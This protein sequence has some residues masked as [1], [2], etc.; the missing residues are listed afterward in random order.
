MSFSPITKRASQLF[1]SDKNIWIA[2]RKHCKRVMAAKSNWAGG[3]ARLYCSQL[4]QRMVCI[5]QHR[6][7]PVFWRLNEKRPDGY[8]IAAAVRLRRMSVESHQ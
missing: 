1:D 5:Y 6:H 3:G 4:D 7:V 2:A 8:R